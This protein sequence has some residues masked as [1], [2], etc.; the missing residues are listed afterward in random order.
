MSLGLFSSGL[1]MFHIHW[2]DRFQCFS[3]L[4]CFSIRHCYQPCLLK[5]S[6][7]FCDVVLAW[8]TSFLPPPTPLLSSFLGFPREYYAF[9]WVC[10]PSM[11]DFI[12]SPSSVIYTLMFPNLHLYP[13]LHLCVSICLLT[14]L[15][16]W[17]LTS[18][19]DLSY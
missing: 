6:L 12:Y 5:Y 1:M 14:T 2:M 7:L 8:F 9:F 16:T 10:K 15:F 18:T 11:N 3:Y 4:T 13:E 17:S 19:C